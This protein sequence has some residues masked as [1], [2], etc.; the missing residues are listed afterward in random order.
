MKQKYVLA[1]DLGTSGVKGA[2]VTLDGSVVATATANYPYQIPAQGWGEQNPE[3]YWRGVCTVTK[4]VLDRS[5]ISPESIAGM[6][7]GT[8]WKGIIPIDRDGNVL[9]SSILW[10]DSRAGDQ[11]RRL[12]EH[13]K[14]QL[15]SPSDYWPK[16]MW[17]RENEPDTVEKAEVILEV[18]SYLKWKATGNASMDISNCYVRSFDPEMDAF[19]AE[20]F[21]FMDFPREK[22]PPFTDAHEMVGHVTEEAARQMG[23]VPG[24]PVFGGNND[25]QGVTV[26]AGCS[27]V[28]GVHIYFGSSGWTGFTVP[29]S[30]MS[31]VSHIDKEREVWM[32]S[33]RAVGRRC[34]SE[35]RPGCGECA[36]RGGG[37]FGHALV[38]QRAYGCGR[39]LLESAA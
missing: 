28:G 24:I 38:L 36:C 17:L 31:R 19:Y 2:L 23:L 1:Y 4:E 21:E 39:L 37:S 9:R 5:G 8:L 14:E 27:A 26:G 10:L 13:F 35:N 33:I 11:A 22:F 7:F 25:I 29:H 30:A 12:N 3:D 34:V 16:L 32:A 18:N 20:V 15:F 6:A